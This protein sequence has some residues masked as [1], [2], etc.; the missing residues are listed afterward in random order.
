MLF[1]VKDSRNK[2]L[3]PSIKS[4]WA[5]KLVKQ[6]KAKWIRKRIIIL[7]LAYEVNE[8]PRDK[9]SYFTIGNDTGTGNIGFAVYKITGNKVL[10]LVSGTSL[11]RSLK[12]KKLLNARAMYRRFRRRV[13]R[14]N[15]QRKGSVPK[16][17]QPRWKNRHKGSRKRFTPTC[18]HLLRSHHRVVEMLFSMVVPQEHTQLNLEYAKFDIQK[19]TGNSNKSGEG[20]GSWKNTQFYVLHRD[21][22]K[23]QYCWATEVE[24]QV[25]HKIQRKD[26]GTDK[27]SNLITLCKKCH[28]NHHK[29]KIDANGL[30][31]D[32]KNG[33]RET[34]L[35]LIMPDFY[36]EMSSQMN[37]VQMFGYET[38]EYRKKYGI[39]KS[40]TNDAKCLGIMHLNR[41]DLEIIDFGITMDMMQFRRHM[42]A[43]VQRKEERTYYLKDDMKKKSVAWNRERRCDQ[44]KDKP[45]LVEYKRMHPN[46]ELVSSQG[47]SVKFN[48]KY[49]EHYLTPGTVVRDLQTEKIHV[50]KSNSDGK[51]YF[52]DARGE[53]VPRKQT[54][55]K[56]KQTVEVIKKFTGMVIL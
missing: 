6:G 3:Y 14:K 52:T 17:R 26:G 21:N 51:S 53:N 29:G 54:K 15:V 12:L 32:E 44:A 49:G 45:S 10:L 20:T 9:I 5:D 34:T 27:P 48:G 46:A 4:T 25:H 47:R 31:G 56:E 18:Q 40:H 37:V 8:S 24:L 13:R 50:V 28:V 41:G 23:C 2:M 7:Q 19:L 16:F 22:H 38:S 36:N 33:M 42:R 55:I 1:F 43:K 11:L 39:E 35:N 30:V